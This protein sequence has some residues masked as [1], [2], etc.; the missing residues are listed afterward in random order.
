MALFVA[1][2]NAALATMLQEDAASMIQSFTEQI[3]QGAFL[4]VPSLWHV[5]VT[6]ALINKFRR[7]LM[8]H[9]EIEKCFQDFQSLRVRTDV[10]S[11]EPSVI[12][13]IWRLAIKH[14][15]TT[16]DATYL[17]LAIRLGCPL[18]TADEALIRSAPLEGI[19]LL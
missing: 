11:A 17:E 9:E 10:Y 12:S 14:Q 6:N 2:A 19:T 5:E 1:D 8:S 15:L 13:H 16:Y 4:A 3:N 7:K 18:L